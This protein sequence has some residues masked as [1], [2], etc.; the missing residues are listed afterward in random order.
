M[1]DSVYVKYLEY[2]NIE[3]DRLTITRSR[4]EEGIESNC[5]VGKGI[6][7]GLM[8]RFLELDRRDAFSDGLP[9]WLRW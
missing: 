3:T 5:L 9:W 4:E 8:E 7:S 2:V 6:Y 1:Y